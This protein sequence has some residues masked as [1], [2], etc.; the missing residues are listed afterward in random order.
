MKENNLELG[1][2][3]S[4]E[5]VKTIMRS[6]SNGILFSVPNDDK[7]NVSEK[8]LRFL[9]CMVN[10]YLSRGDR[11]KANRRERNKH[12]GYQGQ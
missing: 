3:D 2:C 9:E 6:I 7:N 4:S 1:K 12:S 8:I 5:V 10:N 11:I